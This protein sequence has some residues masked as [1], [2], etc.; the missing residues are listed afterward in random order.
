M[1]VRTTLSRRPERPDRDGRNWV[2]RLDG[3]A[4]A[5]ALRARPATTTE[6][7]TAVTLVAL[8]VEVMGKVEATSRRI[9]GADVMDGVIRRGSPAPTTPAR[10]SIAG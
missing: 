2:S 1:L 3:P 7:T 9:G 4:L 5:T 8:A 10:W 6:R